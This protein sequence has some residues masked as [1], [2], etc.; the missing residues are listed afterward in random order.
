[1]NF[2]YLMV[3][4]LIA[5]ATMNPVQAESFS[6][7]NKMPTNTLSMSAMSFANAGQL[8]ALDGIPVEA[9]SAAD[10]DKRDVPKVL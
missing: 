10:M 7:L 1:M 3:G 5:I 6:G 9:M 4:T 8:A 2:K